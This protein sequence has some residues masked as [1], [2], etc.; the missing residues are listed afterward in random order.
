MGE[1]L[2]QAGD[3]GLQLAQSVFSATTC[4]FKDVGGVFRHSAIVNAD[5]R[6]DLIGPTVIWKAISHRVRFKMPILA[7][8]APD[9]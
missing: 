8:I 1:A 5:S 4:Q 6:S 3:L 9:G 2:D 7:C